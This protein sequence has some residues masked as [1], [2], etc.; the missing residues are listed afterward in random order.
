M[1]MILHVAL[2]VSFAGIKGGDYSNTICKG[3]NNNQIV[4]KSNQKNLIDE[5]SDKRLK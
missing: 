5:N 4:T 2:Y 3:V 1:I